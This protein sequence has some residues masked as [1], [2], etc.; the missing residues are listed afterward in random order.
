MRTTENH[1]GSHYRS[2]G[3]RLEHFGGPAQKKNWHDTYFHTL[4]LV[5][6][7]TDYNIIAMFFFNETTDVFF[8]SKSL[9]FL[10]LLGNLLI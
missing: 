6:K 2:I 9:L 7:K 8:F 4:I 1:H 5:F 3:D 10:I